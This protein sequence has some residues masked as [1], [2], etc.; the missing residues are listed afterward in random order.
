MPLTLAHAW[1]G[2]RTGKLLARYCPT[3]GQT[4]WRKPL[5]KGEMFCYRGKKVTGVSQFYAWLSPV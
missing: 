5:V 4:N 3:A 2:A 1:M